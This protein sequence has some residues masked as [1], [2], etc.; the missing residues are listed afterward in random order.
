MHARLFAHSKNSSQS[1]LCLYFKEELNLSIYSLCSIL[2]ILATEVI[3][4]SV[5][6]EL[7]A[8]RCDQY[9]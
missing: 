3:T 1:K 6:S 4:F 7:G 5:K 2:N 8:S 9:C